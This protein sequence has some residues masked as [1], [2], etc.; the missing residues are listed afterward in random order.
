MGFSAGGHLAS[1]VSTHFDAG[2]A[3][4]ADPI[5]RVSCRP[6]FSILCYPV[7]SIGSDFGHKGSQRNLLGDNPDPELLK[8]LSNET[9]VT[10]ETPPTF[11][12]H[13]AEDPGVP[14]RNSLV[15]DTP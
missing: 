3:A 10:A 8:S 12:F 4:A 13:T 1:T 9:Q 14:V 6:D 11:L 15:Y 7:I 5:D 2:Q